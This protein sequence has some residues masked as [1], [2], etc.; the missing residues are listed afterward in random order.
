MDLSM[1]DERQAQTQASREELTKGAFKL[2]LSDRG[3]GR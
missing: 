2:C 1:Q 3:K